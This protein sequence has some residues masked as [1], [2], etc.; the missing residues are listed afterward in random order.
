MTHFEDA[1][2][3]GIQAR[4]EAALM[5]YPNVVGVAA[6]LRTK[7]GQPT[8]EWCLVV[9]VTRKV[10]ASTLAKDQIL[11]TEIEDVPVDVVEVGELRPLDG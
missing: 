7:G 6:G 4:H 10:P 2:V 1:R 9:Y 11:P 5:R 8:R 3:A